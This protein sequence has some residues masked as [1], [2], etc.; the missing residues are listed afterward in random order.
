[1]AA[2][3]TGTAAP[4]KAARPGISD[5]PTTKKLLIKPGHKIASIGAPDT[6]KDSLGTLPDG[7]TIADKPTPNTDAVIAFVRH[8]A[9]V[10]KTLTAANKAVKADGLLWLCYLKGGT[11]AGTDL[12]RDILHQ[13]VKSLGYE[14]VGLISFDDSWSAMRFKPKK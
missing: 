7:A 14:G 6:F 11:K 2:T 1:M 12:N 8:A 10:E 13:Q 3:K 4:S 9:D 5:S